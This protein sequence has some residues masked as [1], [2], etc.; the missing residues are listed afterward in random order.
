MISIEINFNDLPANLTEYI[1]AVKDTE[2]PNKKIG[3]ALFEWVQTE[4]DGEGVAPGSPGPWAPLSEFTKKEKAA[5]GWSPKP[6]LRT[7]NLRQSFQPFSTSDIVGIGAMASSFLGPEGDYASAHQEGRPERR[8]PARPML[9]PTEVVLE[10][11]TRI[12]GLE[13]AKIGK[14]TGLSA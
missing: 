2:V 3:V 10:I 8:L 12:Y 7:G 14:E 1:R 9:P 4:F 13:I 11:A 5:G 6:L